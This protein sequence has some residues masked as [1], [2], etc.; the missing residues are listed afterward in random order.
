MV[1]RANTTLALAIQSE[2]ITSKRQL[3]QSLYP[4][5]QS[6]DQQYNSLAPSY[7]KKALEHQINTLKAEIKEQSEKT[8]RDGLMAQRITYIAQSINGAKNPEGME[9]VV[10]NPR[11]T[12]AQNLFQ[13]IMWKDI[14][15]SK[16][17]LRN[18]ELNL[19]AKK[20]EDH[21]HLQ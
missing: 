14:N 15:E 21:K 12:A 11:E 19:V 3:L 10:Y 16:L 1:Q 13:S 9:R 8:Q 17:M 7:K 20:M 6:I 4:L 5:I 2:S 18:S